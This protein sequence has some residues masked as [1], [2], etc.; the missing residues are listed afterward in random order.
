MHID[1]VI[2]NNKSIVIDL[3]DNP[4]A[5]KYVKIM[6]EL[7]SKHAL[8]FDNRRCFYSWKTNQQIQEDLDNAIQHINN[9][10]K[11]DMFNI[12]VNDPEYF[13]RLH[14]VFERLNQ[15]YDD[16][17]ILKTIATSDLLE[18]IRDINFCVHQL[19]HGRDENSKEITI[20]W[21]KN[22][23]QRVAIG[24]LDYSYATHT[25]KKNTV[26]LGYNEVGKSI[27]D[28]YHDNLPIDYPGLKNNHFV[29][30]DIIFSESDK[31][32][33]DDDFLKWCDSHNIDAF[34]P[35][36]GILNYPIGTFKTLCS[37]DK[38]SPDSKITA[39]DLIDK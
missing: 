12:D 21:N 38:F 6:H 28:L 33:F 7:I 23:I 9:F 15:G 35:K 37:L 16:Q 10:F 8:D 2:D 39:Y 13:N 32:L 17:T 1:I 30:P 11:K 27:L 24:N 25:N 3:F 36:N 29:G 22:T 34:N 31:P 19:E 26:Y 20:Q 5:K 14:I 18:S 4:F